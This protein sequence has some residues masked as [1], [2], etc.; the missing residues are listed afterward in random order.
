MRRLLVVSMG[1]VA[2]LLGVGPDH[3]APAQSIPVERFLPMARSVVEQ[4]NGCRNCVLR[5][6]DLREAHQS[7]PICVAPTC[8]VRICAM[9]ILRER[10]SPVLV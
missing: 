7:V 1:S 4:D 9:P 5:G 6:A 10:I 2:L 3:A 8:R